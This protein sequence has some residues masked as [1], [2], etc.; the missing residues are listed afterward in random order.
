[1]ES[2]ITNLEY[3]PYPSL[4]LENNQIPDPSPD[5]LQILPEENPQD[6]INQDN[7][8]NINQDNQGNINQGN[9]DNINQDNFNDNN[10]S[11]YNLI[12][13]HQFNIQ[14]F[15]INYCSPTY[16]FIKTISNNNCKQIIELKESL[17]NIIHQKNEIIEI[18]ND[19]YKNKEIDELIEKIKQIFS[20][21]NFE[22]LQNELIKI[23][24]NLEKEINISKKNVETFD[25]FIE[26]LNKMNYDNIDKDEL[27]LLKNN[28]NKICEKIYRNNNL[29]KIKN[30][31]IEKRKELNSYIYFIQKLNHW[32]ISNICPVCFTKTVNRFL[33]PC[34]H[35]FCEDCL[36]KSINNHN[37]KFCMICRKIYQKSNSLYFI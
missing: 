23:E 35:T 6:N 28:S 24:K 8:G 15:D 13:P 10:E 11:I 33:D 25:N 2:N 19:E 30:K 36:N 7:Q 22:N 27:D 9:Q 17:L 16:E 29:E 26:F 37:E 3:N 31:Y 18:N 12:E 14:P 34:G 32:N 20:N 4:N 5:P 1:M 21:E